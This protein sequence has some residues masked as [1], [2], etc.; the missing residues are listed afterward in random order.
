[1]SLNMPDNEKGIM[2]MELTCF[3]YLLNFQLFFFFITAHYVTYRKKV[4]VT[5]IGASFQADSSMK[6]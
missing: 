4:S 6:Y 1:M 3:Q 5:P 2:I